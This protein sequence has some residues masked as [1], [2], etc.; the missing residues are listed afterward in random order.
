MGKNSLIR[1]DWAV[2]RLLRQK[3]NFVVLEG[4]LSTLLGERIKIERMLE[5]EGNQNSFDDKFNR[6][7]MLA[8]N[9]RGELVI[10]EVQNNRE[11]DYFHRM[12]YG[13]SKAITEYISKGEAYANVKKVYS[14][15]I[16]YFDLGQGNDYV[17]HGRTEFKGIHTNDVLKLSVHQ[18][19]QF[20]FQ[21]AG[22]LYPE[23]YV[24]RVDE[25]DQKAITPL[26][27]WISFLKTGEIA[28]NAKASGLPEAR[29][30]LR[31]DRLSQAEQKEYDAHMEALRFQRSVIQTGMIEGRAEGKIEGKIEGRAEGLVEGRA[32]GLV[33]GRAEG[34]KVKA[35]TIAH[36]LLHKGISPEDVMELT[37]LKKE[38]M[39]DL[40]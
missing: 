19:E 14:V 33:E 10:I 31:F 24:L 3:S 26:D 29:E 25:F 1:F 18:Q 23:Y 17:Y 16:V 11:L 13:V 22:D 37:G 38:D 6:V 28:A 35:L 8:E 2:K 30:Q 5:S 20:L 12:L 9:S 40:L 39:A 15:N 4:F 34:E 27:E 7:D 32:E 21:D 36:N